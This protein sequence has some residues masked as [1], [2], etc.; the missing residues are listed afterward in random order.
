[1]NNLFKPLFLVLVVLELTACGFQLRQ[2]PPLPEGIEGVSIISPNLQSKL[3]R[4][5][6]SRLK[7]YQL[8]EITTQQT[9]NSTVQITLQPEDL[10]RRLLSIFSTGQVAEYEL[11]Y[12]VNYTVSFPDSAPVNGYVEVLREYQDDPDQ[13]LA[14][15]REL[16]V[17]L[18]EVRQ[19]AADRIIRLLSSQAP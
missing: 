5:L 10:E 6:S 15:S 3:A 8:S 16:E 1:M 17:V 4:A 11:I 2:S 19:E 9:D 7:I 12:S 18:S 14:K 13:V